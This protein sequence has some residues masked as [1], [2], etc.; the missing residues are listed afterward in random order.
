MANISFQFPLLGIFPCIYPFSALQ[1]LPLLSFNSLYLG[2]SLASGWSKAIKRHFYGYFQFPLLGIFPCIKKIWQKQ[3]LQSRTFQFPLLGI[4]PCIR[5]IQ[6]P[7]GT[8]HI[9]FQFPLLGIFPCIRHAAG[10][11]RAV[12][13]RLSIPFTWDF[14]LHQPV[15]EGAFCVCAC[16]FNSLY[17]GFSLA[18]LGL[19]FVYDEVGPVFQFPLLGIFPCILFFLCKT[20]LIKSSLSIP[21]T[22]DFPLHLLLLK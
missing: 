15:V 21:F 9:S 8:L 11:L 10:I 20:S 14:P 18:S 17:L 2:F 16:P 5:T 4:F 3:S 6:M 7:F 12:Q 19:N 22:W 13:R 1:P